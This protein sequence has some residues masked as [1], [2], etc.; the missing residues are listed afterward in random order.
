[1]K[2]FEGEE[3]YVQLV[4]LINTF[5]YQSMPWKNTIHFPF[6]SIKNDLFHKLLLYTYFATQS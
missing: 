6:V 3:V 5:I 1:M 4:Y 2:S